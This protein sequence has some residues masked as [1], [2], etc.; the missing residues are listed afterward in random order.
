MT[1]DEPMKNSEG[2]SRS[3]AVA[4]ASESD[5]DA[6]QVR[7]QKQLF[8]LTLVFAILGVSSFRFVRRKR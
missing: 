7:S 6:E 1:E 3:P 2:I 8:W 5:V 4:Q